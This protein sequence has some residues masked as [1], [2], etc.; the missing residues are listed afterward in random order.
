M[1]QPLSR[2]LEFLGRIRLRLDVLFGH[3][4]ITVGDPTADDAQRSQLWRRFTRPEK[5][6]DVWGPHPESQ[7]IP[8]HAIPIFAALDRLPK[9]KIG[10][11]APLQAA[12][13]NG[14]YAGSPSTFSRIAP[15]S[16]KP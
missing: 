13:A 4:D 11:T 1:W 2:T 14:V 7:W 16:R 3:H 5:L 8:F 12:P 6:Y 15:R 10:P 9:E